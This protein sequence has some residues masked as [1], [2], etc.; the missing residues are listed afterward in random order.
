VFPKIKFG[1][2]KR[3]ISNVH[4]LIGSFCGASAAE[5]DT[6]ISGGPGSLDGR[7]QRGSYSRSYLYEPAATEHGRDHSTLPNN[8]RNWNGI[9]VNSVPKN[10]V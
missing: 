8:N 1:Y 4:T 10:P 5:V 7:K 3:Q 2:R 6:L 9:L